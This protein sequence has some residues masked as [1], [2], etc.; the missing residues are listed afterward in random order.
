MWL[1]DPKYIVPSFLVLW[2]TVSLLISQIS[3]WAE[4]ARYY[5]STNLFQGL[6]WRFCS[7]RMRLTTRYNGCLTI[8]ADGY[9]LYL[10]VFFPFRL[11][12]PD[13]FVPWQY[14]T[15]NHGKTLLWKWIEFRFQQTPHVWLRLYGTLA[16]EIKSAAGSSWPTADVISN[17]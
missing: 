11:G 3:G 9:G 8:G 6:R 4:L 16:D 7:G 2:I 10:A 12:H 5:R 17:N 15:V 1:D 13:L 14:V